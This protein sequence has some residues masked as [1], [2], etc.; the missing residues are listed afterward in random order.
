MSRAQVLT[1][2]T[3]DPVLA[4]DEAGL[5]YVSD[6][7]PGI[8]RIKRG[9]SVR[10]VTPDGKVIKD[11]ATLK[12]I[13]ALVIPP[14]WTDV[15]I[16]ASA[17]GHLQA[18]GRDVKG[19]KQYRYHSAY[20]SQRDHA[21]FGRMLA[22]G[23]A[24]PR[25]RKRIDDDLSL[26]GLPKNKV[27]SAVLHLLEST[28]MRIGNDEY[29]KQNE[30]Y[31]LTTLQDGHVKISGGKMR[32]KFR[33]K[34]GQQQDIELDDPRLAKIVKKCRDIPGWELF[35]YFDESGE[36]C[37]ITSTDVNNYIREISGED[38]TA[39]DFR[40][41]GGTGWAALFFE[42]LGPA[43]DDAD[44]KKRM[45]E[46]IKSVSAKLGNRPATCRKYYVHPAILDA[47]SDKTLFDVLKT[48][49]GTRRQEA[50]VIQV[51]TEYVK[52]L[53]DQ[54]DLSGTLRKSLRR[55]SRQPL[56]RRA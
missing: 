41:W 27:L 40:T 49:R 16:C 47:Y 21:K 23:A 30:S 12:R 15:W 51:V 32:F 37:R 22:F 46:A 34:S 10:Y 42:E 55:N 35:Q 1:I 45:V 50:C 17:Y 3:K 48:C 52:K 54:Q 38:F 18:V 56:R 7:T 19:R 13:R 43:E 28:C 11:P 29:V 14:G 5:E 20:R 39:K 31:G 4:A 33:G 6:R 44:A 26:P 36:S 25:I 8:R 9:D 53:K 24:L 2:H